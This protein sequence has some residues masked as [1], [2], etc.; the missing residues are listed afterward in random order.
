MDRFERATLLRAL[1]RTPPLL[2]LANAW[3]AGSARVL[4]ATGLKA[5]ATTSSGVAHS[6][7]RP[8]GEFL[9]RAEMIDAIAR[10]TRAVDTPVSADLERGYGE[11]AAD[12]AETV[13][14]AIDAGVVG[15]NL[16]DGVP[17]GPHLRP[18][19]EQCERLA[20]A[21]NAADAS[22]VPLF[23]NAR[24]DVWLHAVGHPDQRLAIALERANAYLGAGADGIFTPGVVEP[25]LIKA[26]AEGVKAP[27]NLFYRPGLPTVSEL[28]TLGVS[29]LSLGGSAAI[30]ALGLLRR[31]ATELQE[32]GTYSL[33]EAPGMTYP[34]LQQLFAKEAR[35]T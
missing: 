28:E 30:A 34:E 11:T 9:S 10:I 2:L 16:E 32:S 35:T 26:L 17:G 14:Q 33:L 8:D 23:I 25:S 4:E 12:V 18:I 31:I 27:L 1:H 15:V 22:G 6:L 20:A 24:V 29:R 5:L 3:D 13:R 19:D 21:R 7:G